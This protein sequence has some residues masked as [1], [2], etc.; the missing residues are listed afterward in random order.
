M[1]RTSAP[2]PGETSGRDQGKMRP[3]RKAFNVEN[4]AAKENT[5][6]IAD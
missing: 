4:V 2:R 6:E 5:Y 3:F 1:N